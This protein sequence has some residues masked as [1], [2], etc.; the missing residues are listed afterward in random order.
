MTKQVFA[1]ENIMALWHVIF[2]LLRQ[3]TPKAPPHRA[4]RKLDLVDASFSVD[5]D[6]LSLA[7]LPTSML[8]TVW[9]TSKGILSYSTFPKYT[10]V[11]GRTPQDVFPNKGASTQGRQAIPK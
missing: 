1:G 3:L 10:H 9:R 6:D 5:W 4:L 7:G 11:V 2:F 8:S